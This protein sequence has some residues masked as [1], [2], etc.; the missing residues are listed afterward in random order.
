MAAQSSAGEEQKRAGR[1]VPRPQGAEHERDT[2]LKRAGENEPD[3]EL[4]REHVRELV[5]QRQVTEKQSGI[6]STSLPMEGES[7]DHYPQA[8]VGV[9]QP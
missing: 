1:A 9:T 3:R 4:A 8:A 5:A 7:S 6:H 2:G